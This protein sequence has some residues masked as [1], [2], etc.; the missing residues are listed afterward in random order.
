MTTANV[1]R[2]API[3]DAGPGELCPDLAGDEQGDDGGR[4]QP[5]AEE[6]PLDRSGGGIAECPEADK[7]RRPRNDPGEGGG[8]I[9]G[10]GNGRYAEQVVLQIERHQRAEAQQQDNL[11]ALLGDGVVDRCEC[12]LASEQGMNPWACQVARYEKGQRSGHC[13]GGQYDRECPDPVDHAGSDRQWPVWC[14]NQRGGDEDPGKDYDAPDPEADNPALEY[15]APLADRQQ[16]PAD[17]QD[18]DNPA[19]RD[20]GPSAGGVNLSGT[21]GLRSEIDIANRPPTP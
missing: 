3:I 16:E 8:S 4:Q 19:E 21:K 11:P 1:R 5:D 9:V 12:R 2:S 7:E 10:E 6:S 17:A 18:H 20:P 15:S 13:G 14:E